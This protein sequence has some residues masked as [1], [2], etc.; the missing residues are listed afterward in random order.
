MWATSL[1]YSIEV[2]IDRVSSRHHSHPTFQVTVGLLHFRAALVFRK[3]PA[4]GRSKASL[5][6]MV[7]RSLGARMVL[8]AMTLL[9]SALLGSL[10]NQ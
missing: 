4:S 10:G 3:T 1:S 5:T 8:T 7:L 6:N 2:G 9:R